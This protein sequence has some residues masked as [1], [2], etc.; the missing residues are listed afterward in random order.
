MAAIC[1]CSWIVVIIG[2]WSVDGG[3][4]VGSMSHLLIKP[5]SPLVMN[6]LLGL[7]YFLVTM[8]LRV[9][10]PFSKIMLM[11]SYGNT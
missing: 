11:L 8:C 5:V 7:E 9:G 3:H 4:R 1:W 10:T 6:M 2:K